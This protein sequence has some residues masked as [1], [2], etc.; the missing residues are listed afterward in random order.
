MQRVLST[1]PKPTRLKL[2]M[3]HA[4]EQVKYIRFVCRAFLW[5]VSPYVSGIAS[6]AVMA[7][8]RLWAGLQN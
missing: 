6:G 7:R 8:A 2:R 5:V 3:E 4:A 1:A